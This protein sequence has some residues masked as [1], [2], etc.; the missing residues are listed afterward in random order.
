MKQLETRLLGHTG[1]NVSVISLGSGRVLRLNFADA[2][3]RRVRLIQESIE[4]GIN[5]FDTADSYAFGWD[6][7]VLGMATRNTGTDV[8]IGTKVG[9][10]ASC[11]G[12]ISRKFSGRAGQNFDRDYIHKQC[13]RSLRLLQRNAIDV[14]YLHSPPCERIP[15]GL[16]AL[17]GLKKQGKI[18]YTGIAF[19]KISDFLSLPPHSVDVV[20][21]PLSADPKE[22]ASAVEKCGQ[23]GLGCVIRQP[24]Y[25]QKEWLANAKELDPGAP[26]LFLKML[27]ARFPVSSFL[28]S[29][30]NPLNLRQNVS[31]FAAS[32][33]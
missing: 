26:D 33:D 25:Y 9:Y 5:F 32:I 14:Y 28:F 18:R 27:A 2:I 21:I 4:L 1:L 10:P 20:Q 12:K 8:F 13:D 30:Q 3:R 17:S 16:E 24:F 22:L 23:D 11:L 7:R 19:G 6:E 31:R 15:E 29:T